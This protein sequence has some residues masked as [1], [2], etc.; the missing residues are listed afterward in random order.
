MKIEIVPFGKIHLEASRKYLNDREI[1]RLFNRTYKV[2]SPK[3]QKVW[4]ENIKKDKTQLVCA[5]HADGIYIGN[6][7]FKHIDRINKKAEFYIFIGNKNFWGKGIGS[8]AGRLLLQS[9]KNK[10]GLHKIYLHVDEKNSR[11]IKLYEKLS[12]IAE[13]ILKDEITREGKKI[14][15]IRMAYFFDKK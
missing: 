8:I 15:L 7:G 14:T 5:I 12:F 11:A 3:A 9:A 4:F 13:G 2:I 10:F 6:A 1:S